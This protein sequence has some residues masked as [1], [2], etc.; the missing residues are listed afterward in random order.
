MPKKDPVLTIGLIVLAAAWAMLQRQS[1]FISINQHTY[2][3]FAYAQWQGILAS[4]WFINTTH[5]TPLFTLLTY[6]LLKYA[7]GFISLHWVYFGLATFFYYSLFR[8]I[9]L[10]PRL[11]SI[12][13]IALLSILTISL[14]VWQELLVGH[15]FN[16]IHQV[17]GYE[18]HSWLFFPEFRRGLAQ[19]DGL[20]YYQP[21]AFGML[22]M[23]QLY[24][25]ITNR[26]KLAVLMAVLAGSFHTSF[27]LP[28]VLVTAWYVAFSQPRQYYLLASQMLGLLPVIAYTLYHFWPMSPEAQAILFYERIPHHADPQY[29]FNLIN[30]AKLCTIILALWLWFRPVKWLW[31]TF[32]T[33]FVLS[34]CVAGFRWEWL[35]LLFPWRYSTVLAPLAY[36]SLAFGIT[37]WAVSKVKSYVLLPYAAGFALVVQ[38]VLSSTLIQ[39]VWYLTQPYQAKQLPIKNSIPDV[40]TLLIPPSSGSLRLNT[41]IPVF[42]DYKNHPYKSD[43]I[44][45]WNKRYKLAAAYYA[46]PTAEHLASILKHDR[47]ITHVLHKHQAD[48]EGISL[49]DSSQGGWVYEVKAPYKSRP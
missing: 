35:G 1:P 34:V 17:W 32:I 30:A 46:Q 25:L 23:P 44:M 47:S 5:S 9:T 45:E 19:Q 38:L 39:N 48:F 7:G 27:I 4:D 18:V 10:H 20:T 28:G 2:L 8:I 26:P 29:W 42:I 31:A 3:A 6:G 33:L 40:Q 11:R 16:A 24:Y 36:Y 22:L 21:A 43:E 13:P 37:L 49:V 14:L 15:L 41:R 12:P